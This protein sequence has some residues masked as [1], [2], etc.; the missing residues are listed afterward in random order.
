[1]STCLDGANI[2]YF[3]HADVHYSQ[4]DLVVN[5]LIKMGEQPLV[6]MP[7]KYSMPRFHIS[8][9]FLQKLTQRELEILERYGKSRWTGS[10][11][12][13]FY[14]SNHAV[15]LKSS[16]IL[17]VVPSR[18]LDDYYWMLGSVS[19]QTKSRNGADLSISPGPECGR[20]PGLRPI[21]V[22]ND[23]MRDHKLALLEPRLFRRWS[24]SHIVNY[25]ISLYEKDEWEE[26][27]V[28]FFPADFFSREIQSNTLNA[29]GRAW[30]FPVAEW[31][32]Y[33]RLCIRLKPTL[34]TATAL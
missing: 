17:Y 10:V 11:E 13:L 5:E 6:I 28:R 31:G 7:E 9:G 4:I 23:Q 2:A 33:D 21:L 19:N 27:Q 30:H 1:M 22:S 14:L 8:T 26:R 12:C 24:S 3:G 29:D 32:D 15:R 34:Q 20:F 25:N 18:C 16:G